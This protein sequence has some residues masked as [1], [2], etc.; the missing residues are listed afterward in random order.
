M[1]ERVR[2]IVAQSKK[3]SELVSAYNKRIKEAK[4]RRRLT[5]SLLNTATMTHC[6]IAKTILMTSVAI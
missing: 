4:T 5:N 2:E 1:F 3:N 6:S